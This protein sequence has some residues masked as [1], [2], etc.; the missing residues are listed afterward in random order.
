MQLVPL[1]GKPDQ[2]QTKTDTWH[3][4]DV[5]NDPTLSHEGFTSS[6]RP[7]TVV[8]INPVWIVCPARRPPAA[9]PRRVASIEPQFCT[10]MQPP[11]RDQQ[12]QQQQE[13][14]P[15]K[16]GGPPCDDD[17]STSRPSSLTSSSSTTTAMTAASSSSSSS[18]ASGVPP[19][20]AAAAAAARAPVPVP[21]S[22]S[23]SSAAAPYFYCTCPQYQAKDLERE[24]NEVLTEQ[25]WIEADADLRGT[26][27]ILRE[28]PDLVA[29]CLRD[30]YEALAA[31]PP[32]QKHSYLRAVE[33]TS[34]EFVLRESP[35]P[36]AFLRCE[37]FDPIQAARRFVAYWSV[38]H[39]IFGDDRAFR[40]MCPTRTSEKKQTALEEGRCDDDD[41]DDDDDDGGCDDD[42]N[43]DDDDAGC[44]TGVDWEALHSGTAKE[45]PHDAYGRAVVVFKA[46]CVPTELADRQPVMVRVCASF[47]QCL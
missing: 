8:K 7:I 9:A 13:L 35:S 32:D 37:Q 31:I 42:P 14:K 3:S 4:D 47:V 38:R 36:L 44:M 6:P 16:R 46:N 21:S 5:R 10:T 40:C 17:E 26:C 34:K 39:T 43:D 27:A 2:G 20:A 33:T 15:K 30:F 25:E 24:R 29:A 19:A 22:P 28:P 12:Q 23:S 45:L 18:S 11:E 1:C 41:D